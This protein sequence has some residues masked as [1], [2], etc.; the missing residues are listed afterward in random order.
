MA[1]SLFDE[2]VQAQIKRD[3]VSSMIMVESDESDGDDEDPP[4]RAELKGSMIPLL[5]S[6]ATRKSMNLL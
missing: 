4:K 6:F 5:E 2:V 1:L 3:I